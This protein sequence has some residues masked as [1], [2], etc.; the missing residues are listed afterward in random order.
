MTDDSNLRRSRLPF[1]D[2]RVAGKRTVQIGEA[3]FGGPGLAII[4]GPCV[5]ESAD[6]ALTTAAE[7]RRLC[8]ERS[9]AL[10]FK[11]SYVKANRSS[12]SSFTGPGLD[13]GLEILSRVRR[14]TG[15][16]LL[17]DV[18]EVAE[19]KAAAE[20]VDCLQI[21]A[22][23]S[24]QTALLV[25]AAA[26]GRVVNVK[27]GQ[28]LAPSDM[29]QVAGKL[30]SAGARGVL[31]TERGVSF[32]YNNLVV[33]FRSFV[34]MRQLGWPVVYDASHSLQRPGGEIT[35]GDRSHALPLARAAVACGV[36]ALFFETHPRPEAAL[37]D[38]ATQ[39]PLDWVPEL[40]DQVL[41]V[42]EA[43][44]EARQGGSDS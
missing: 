20:V 15:L 4:A 13:E 3:V 26:S 40:L 17:T 33:D 27:K 28:F 9:L 35:G 32:G 21:P 22:F 14:E 1:P 42:R 6:L 16:P 36:D 30:E 44:T 10:V 38:A 18:H 2:E 12:V 5:L 24:R 31:L 7:L 37:S 25:A 23:L 39:F 43:V 34:E 19:V 29:K 11:S 8:D 41:R